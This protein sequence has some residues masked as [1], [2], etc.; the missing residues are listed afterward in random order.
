MKRFS[1]PISISNRLKSLLAITSFIFILFID[2][3]YL[4]SY[5]PILSGKCNNISAHFEYS[6]THGSEDH[7]LLF[8]LKSNS[9]KSLYIVESIPI[10]E[11][12]SQNKYTSTIW[13]PPKHINNI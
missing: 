5:Q 1:F 3:C 13:Q 8:G 12:C 10:S 7:I 2:D 9:I 11:G 6:H 4:I